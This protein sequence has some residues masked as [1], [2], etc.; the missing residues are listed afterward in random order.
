MQN[1]RWILGDG[2]DID[3]IRH[4]WIGSVPLIVALPS[5][6]QEPFN[7]VKDVVDNDDHPFRRFIDIC[8]V[9]DYINLS[10]TP[11][12]CVWTANANGNFSASSAFQECTQNQLSILLHYC[13]K[14]KVKMKMPKVVRWSPP[15]YGFSLNVDGAYKGNLGPCG[16]GG[17]IR[18][19][20]GD[21]CLGFAFFYG[22]GNSVIAEVHALCDGL[23]LAEYHG[24]PIS[25]V[26]SD[27][28]ALVHSLKSNKCP[29]W[30]CIWWWRAA[31][32]LLCKSTIQLVHA[33][34]ETNRV[35]DEQHA[36][37]RGALLLWPA[38][39]GEVEALVSIPC[40]RRPYRRDSNTPW[41][42]STQSTRGSTRSTGNPIIASES[43]A[44]SASTRE[45]QSS[46]GHGAK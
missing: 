2:K 39:G 10:N 34:R 29:S 38:E 28:L 36:E 30:K 5:L 12:R 32:Y 43:S 45:L 17:C 27:S 25:I 16:G 9:L 6:A 14:P 42:Q 20:N 3:I 26:H 44:A 18:D 23:R 41:A 35:A 8:M 31:S 33:Y 13:F 37:D 22:Q 21:I 15:Q 4:K 1:S 11:D 46:A 7:S 19:S 40:A 24:I